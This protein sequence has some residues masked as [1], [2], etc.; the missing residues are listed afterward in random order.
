MERKDLFFML[1]GQELASEGFQ[2][3]KAKS[4]FIKKCTNNEYIYSFDS[5]TGFMSFEP[6]FNILIGEVEDVK[7]KAWNKLY[8]K[9]VSVGNSKRYLLPKEE[10]ENCWSWTDTEEAVKKAVI[11]EADFYYSFTKEYYSTYSGIPFLDAHLNSSPNETRLI[12]Y[13]QIH[14]SFL[15]IIVA[16]LTNNPNIADLIPFYK[17]I[18]KKVNSVYITEFEL[19]EHY[20]ARV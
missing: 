15:A 17:A 19:L 13:N 12:A 7:K 1:L 2:Y 4:R 9:F 20:I 5:S 10:R 11:K 3:N 14:T 6:H 18:V 16:Y 8:K